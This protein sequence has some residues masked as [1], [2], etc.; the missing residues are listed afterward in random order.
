MFLLEVVN[1]MLPYVEN[2][3]IIAVF[4]LL[5][6]LFTPRNRGE[7]VLLML[8]VVVSQ[9]RHGLRFPDAG[10]LERP[11][12]GCGPNATLFQ[13]SSGAHWCH[14]QCPLPCT[15]AASATAEQTCLVVGSRFYPSLRV[16]HRT[17]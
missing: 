14:W 6:L 5:V 11:R 16:S 1:R 7:D 8:F 13:L 4:C 17:L 10:S 3:S 9:I 2:S 12:A 15:Q